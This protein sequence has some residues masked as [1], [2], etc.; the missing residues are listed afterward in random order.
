MLLYWFKYQINVRLFPLD[1]LLCEGNISFFVFY[2]VG[3]L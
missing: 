1:P 2:S 3:I